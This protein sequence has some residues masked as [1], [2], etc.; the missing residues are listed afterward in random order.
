MVH[1]SITIAELFT[2]LLALC[3]CGY[4]LLCIFSACSFLR[5]CARRQSPSF[6]P[7]VSLL[8]PLRGADREMYGA[9]RSHCLQDYP[10]FEIIFGVS[11][12]DDP[13]IGL[14][15]QLKQEFPDRRIELVFCSGKLGTNIKVSNLAQMLPHAQNDYLLVSDSDIRVEPDY[16]RKVISPLADSRVGMVTTLYRGA[17]AHTLASHLEAV[18]ISTDFAAGVLSAR[19]VD[20]GIHFGLGSTLAFKRECLNA[21]GGFDPLLDYLADDYELG[22]RIDRSGYQVVLADEIVDTVL[23]DYRFPDFWQHQLRWMRTVKASRGWGYFGLLLTFGLPFAIITAIL[24][25]GAVWSLVLLGGTLALR[26]TMAYVLASRVMRDHATLRQLWLL[27]LRDLLALAVW[28]AGYCSNTIVWRGVR[29]TLKDGRLARNT[30]Q[31]L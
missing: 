17:S 4:Y 20:R 13:A 9:L 25:R 10:N 15:E 22:N 19:I 2:G 28:A 30:C 8:K 26:F 5:D 7:P 27:P 3:G 31:P 29:F 12:A 18:G 16:L 21:I 1:N 23:P 24:A 14:V 6:T 11:E